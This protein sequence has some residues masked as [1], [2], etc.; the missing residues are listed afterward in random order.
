MFSHWA[1]AFDTVSSSRDQQNT[2]GKFIISNSFH[3]GESSDS[4]SE[5]L[6]L[7]SGMGFLS[8]PQC[9]DLKQT[10]WFIVTEFHITLPCAKGPTVWERRSD[11]H[12]AHWAYHVLNHP[13]AANLARCINLEVTSYKLGIQSSRCRI[14]LESKAIIRCSVFNRYNIWI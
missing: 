2:G 7:F 9:C 13:E 12:R 14:Y 5:G 3:S 10:A 8:C 1:E 4:S 6:I 11:I